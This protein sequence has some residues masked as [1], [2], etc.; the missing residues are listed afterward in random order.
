MDDIDRRLLNAVQSH[1]PMTAEPYDGL[2][3]LLD[4]SGDAV[5]ERIRAFMQA[6]I[7]RQISPVVDA[8]RL[9]YQSTLVAMKVPSEGLDRAAQA[10][11][12]HPGISHGYRRDHEYNVWVTLALPGDS[13][14]RREL[15]NLAG[16]AGAEA[17]FDMPALKVFKLRTHF[18]ADGEE[19]GID[20]GAGSSVLPQKAALSGQ[21]KLVINE[22]QQPLP[23]H[24]APFAPMAGRLGM[25][26][27]DFLACCRSLLELGVIRRYGA[28]I[29]HHKAGYKA[30]AMTC[31]KVSPGMTEEV[32]QRLAALREVS[33]CYERKT[34][35]RWPYNVF[36]MIHGRLREDCHRIVAG[37]SRETGLDE[38]AMLFSTTEF[39]KVRVR[40]PA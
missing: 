16:T 26:L 31:W 38:Y 32:G 27:D 19:P 1:F 23:L 20:T 2:G 24:R 40:Y 15:D 18:G 22:L 9:G 25:S 11:A 34:D 35:P 5:I 37:L 10:I 17:V 39:K 36:A 14:V 6:G 4:I 13:D 12:E 8:R 3:G 7:I 28:A 30:N 33:H 21:D 29:N